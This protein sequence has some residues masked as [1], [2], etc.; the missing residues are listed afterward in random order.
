LNCLVHFRGIEELDMTIDIEHLETWIGRTEEKS[1]T[2]TPA[3]LAGLS[4]T[5]D[6]ADP[7]PEAG[8][9]VPPAGHWL[10]FLPQAPQSEIGPDGHPHR[11][12]FL[13]PVDLPRR[14]WAG[15]R[16]EFF[17]PLRVGDVIKRISTI[18]DVTHRTGQTGELVF[19]IVQH[20]VFGPD[21]LSIREEH[22]IVYR[23]EPDPEAPPPQIKPAPQDGQWVRSINP[24]PVLL[25][26]YSALTFNGHRIHYDLKYVT[27]EEGYPG[28]IVHGPL[29]ATMLIDLAVREN[30]TRVLEKF[31][32]RAVSPVFDTAPFT[33][34][35][36]PGGDGNTAEL[37]IANAH[38][39]L[40]MKADATFAVI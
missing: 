37:W 5:L 33:V 20:E 28:L 3:Q 25:F 32:Y 9:A 17:G 4:A 18:K 15:G 27:E 36:K 24:D 2:V 26:R 29:M 12:G 7:Y 30:P 11:G 14:M 16:I 13:P 23:G 31:S 38:G 1:D 21:G 8:T 22:D 19:V 34:N 10:F 35:G 39:T 6:H 40:A